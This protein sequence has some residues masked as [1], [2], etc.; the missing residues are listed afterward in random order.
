MALHT[1]NWIIFILVLL[2]G[3]LPK[4]D[5]RAF[6]FVVTGWAYIFYFHPP[7]LL[8]LLLCS[9][10]LMV[11]VKSL[12]DKQIIWIKSALLVIFIAIIISYE[13]LLYWKGRLD[14]MPLGSTAFLINILRYFHVGWHYKAL[15]AQRESMWNILA[16]MWFPPLMF[17]GPLET[18]QEFREYH[19]NPRPANWA[20]GIKL[21]I[22]GL[23]KAAFV[24]ILYMSLVTINLNHSQAQLWQLLLRL[25]AMGFT[26]M[27]SLSSWFDFSRGWCYIMGYPFA[28]PN[29]HQVHKVKSVA[30]FWTHYNI[31][32]SRWL[33]RHLFFK[34]LSH[35]KIKDFL[36]AIV[37]YFV[38]I[39]V[40]KSVSTGFLLWGILH[41]IAVVF[42]FYYI[43]LK[44]KYNWLMILDSRYFPDFIKIILTQTFVLMTWV[45][46]FDDW[47]ILYSEVFA[48]LG[49]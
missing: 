37:L 38:V 8:V 5:I 41:G 39:A 17:C 31:S 44:L 29:F 46:W 9:I 49:F 30:S 20:T 42:N 32:L 1:E 28:S 16:Y 40:M 21:L 27:F 18:Y 13:T 22:Y 7:T 34:A 2:V 26:I 11:L 48:K 25:C 33:K 36:S 4:K 23:L 19:I 47:Y 10:V 35:F 15:V 14:I 6:G 24:Y 45:L 3:F 12:V 43:Y